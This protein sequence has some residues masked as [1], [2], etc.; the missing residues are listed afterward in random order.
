MPPSERDTE[1]A[2][3]PRAH[4]LRLSSRSHFDLAENALTKAIARARSQGRTLLDLTESNPTHANLPYPERAILDALG[5]ARALTYEPLPFGLRSAREAAARS[6]G[7][8]PERVFLTASTSE[9]YAF[10]FKVLCDPGDE[11]LVP[12]PSYPLFEHLATLEGVRLVPYRL[13][14]DGAWHVDVDSVHRARSDKTRLVLSV[15]PNNPT[16][17][18]LKRHEL[19]A[20]AALGL[21]IVSDEV[22]ADYGFGEDEARVKTVLEET[23]VLTFALS[24]LSKAAALPQMKAAWTCVG[25]PEAE[26]KAV[27]ERLEIVADSFLSVSTPVQHALPALLASR[28]ATASAI[29]ARTARNLES[30]RGQVHPRVPSPA[31]ILDVEGGWYATLRIPRTK[32]EEAWVVGLVEEDGVV[33]HPGAFFDFEDEAH[34]VVSLLTEERVFDEG[35]TRVLASVARA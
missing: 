15:S 35:I 29:R 2:R 27:L 31:S 21:P 24:G 8:D 34:L 7:R 10:L 13:A 11:A 1:A 22:F 17:S 32:S 4:A 23:N 5:D 20:L 3:S 14:Y 26:V 33:V 30:L 6:I 18:F 25:G 16:G 28:E 12:A 19:R 9:A